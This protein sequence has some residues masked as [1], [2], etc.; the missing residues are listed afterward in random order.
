MTVNLQERRHEV[1]GL[2]ESGAA[3]HYIKIVVFTKHNTI[4]VRGVECGI[5][6]YG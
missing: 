5:V 3:C 2:A 1:F 6:L 4:A